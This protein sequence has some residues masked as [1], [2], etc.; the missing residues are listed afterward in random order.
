MTVLLV[1]LS[2]GLRRAC[3]EEL[4]RGG[5]PAE[6]AP[7]EDALRRLRRAV[8]QVL[9]VD[10]SA[11][12]ER[13]AM[14]VRELRRDAGLA[15]LPVVGIAGPGGADQELMAAGAHCCLRTRAGP[16]DVLRAVQ[17]AAEVYG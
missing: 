8:P 4:A 13:A 5:F 12:P 14:L 16:S 10:G 1:E 6:D 11:E 7:W 17:W 2:P 15:D 3:A 9:V